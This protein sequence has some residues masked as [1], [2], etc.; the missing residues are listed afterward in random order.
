M[1][2]AAFIVAIGWLT[3]IGSVGLAQESPDPGKEP[4]NG[5][6]VQDGAK[7]ETEAT[8]WGGLILAQNADTDPAP[9]PGENSNTTTSPD[10]SE[11]QPDSVADPT[12]FAKLRPGLATIFAGREFTL[13]GEHRQALFKQYESWVVPSKEIFLKVD[14]RGP[15]EGGGVRLHLQLW[16]DDK[17][18]V[19][20]DAVLRPGSPLFIG[21]PKWRDGQLIFAVALD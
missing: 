4:G 20:T 14:S 19:K 15:A 13:L 18:L 12:P 21:G 17:V 3:A 9:K 8:I 16:Q 1:K 5:P 2:R 10:S 7:A 6:A 11:A